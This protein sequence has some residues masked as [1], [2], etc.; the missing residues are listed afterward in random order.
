MRC[1][2]KSIQDETKSFCGMI[3]T[4]EF[5]FKTI[6]QVI[7]NAMHFTADNRLPCERCMEE[8]KKGLS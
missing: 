2:V 1:H 6:E 4:T 8:I 7:I 3:L 5:Y